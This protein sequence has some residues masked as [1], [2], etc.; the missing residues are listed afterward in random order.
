MGRDYQKVCSEREK[1]R[2]T[3][4]GVLDKREVVWGVND[5]KRG[6]ETRKKNEMQ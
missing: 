3:K 1:G 5:N 6:S 2:A 4:A